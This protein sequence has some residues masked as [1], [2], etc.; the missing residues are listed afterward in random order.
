MSTKF[1][2]RENKISG[3]DRGR[4]LSAVTYASEPTDI[5][6]INAIKQSRHKFDT[7]RH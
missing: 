7:T 2:D 5:N 4:N 1:L 3:D 6:N